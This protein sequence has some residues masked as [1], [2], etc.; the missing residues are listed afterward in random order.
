MERLTEEM[1]RAAK[2]LDFETAAS[3]RDRIE[4]LELENELRGP[5][6]VNRERQRN[7]RRKGRG[8]N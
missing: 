3:L 7:A 1:Y 4:E 6:S 5:D 2:N 8:R